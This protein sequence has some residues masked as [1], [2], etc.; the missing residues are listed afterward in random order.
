MLYKSEYD[1]DLSICE[2][3][4]YGNPTGRF[5]HLHVEWPHEPEREICLQLEADNWFVGGEPIWTNDRLI[6]VCGYS[7][8]YAHRVPMVGNCYWNL[9]R[10][11]NY[12]A[13]GL[14]NV[15]LR[16]RLFSL[17]EGYSD[18]YDAHRAG[19]ALTMADFDYK[20]YPAWQHTGEGFHIHGPK[21]IDLFDATN[22]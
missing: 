7:F 15:L 14:I 3:N 19:R 16:S 18:L 5:S 2:N 4:A 1:I 9:Y 12:Y 22:P 6:Q 13:I 10:L 11:P 8:K 20:D 17:E 21:Q